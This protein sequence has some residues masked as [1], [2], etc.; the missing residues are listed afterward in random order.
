MVM[1]DTCALLWAAKAPARLPQRVRDLL[2]LERN[3]Q[4]LISVV[5]A[6]ELE[7]KK[8]AL[9]IE[10]PTGWFER[11]ADELGA[12]V[13]SIRL[14]HIAALQQLPARHKDP[15]DR[16]LVAQAIAEKCSLVT[17]DD[18]I[19]QYSEVPCIWD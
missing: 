7:L 18:D 2:L 11:S 14:D 16:I 15:F 9:K 17:V 12:T 4:V 6:W 19:R 1:L 3:E 8:R 10:D 5:S 13:L